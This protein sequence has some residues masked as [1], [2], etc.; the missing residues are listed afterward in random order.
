M[1]SV[2]HWIQSA[3]ETDSDVRDLGTVFT[4]LPE[5]P[6]APTGDGPLT[7]LSCCVKDV[8]DVGGWPTS[9]GSVGRTVT[10]ARDAAA[11]ARLRAAGASL[12]GKGNT[13][14][15][16]LG[17]D[18]LNPHHGPA[19][20]PHDPNRLAG[21]SSSGPA[22]AVASGLADIGLGTDTSGS[23]RVPAA[24]CGIVGVRPTL[25]VVPVCGVYP[26]ASA[27]D[28]VGPLA[29]DVITAA[30]A[31]A[32]LTG[33]RPV[34]AWSALDEPP[35]AVPKGLTFAVPQHIVDEWC[36][37]GVRRAL[38]AVLDAMRDVG[39]TVEEIRLPGLAEITTAHKIIQ[40]QQAYTVHAE[41]LRTYRDCYSEPVLSL[42]EQGQAIT[43][44][45]FDDAIG[46]REAIRSVLASAIRRFGILALPSAA[47]VAPPLATSTVVFPGGVT[48]VRGALLAMTIPFSQSPGPTVALPIGSDQGLPVGVQLH[49]GAGG[50]LMTLKAA[51][52]VERA[53]GAARLTTGTSASRAV[54]LAE[55][56]MVPERRMS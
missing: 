39:V 53:A 51:L 43:P 33:D 20:N 38:S 17:I 35:P 37:D 54:V 47:L 2:A 14:E 30:K 3:A 44:D 26:I 7:G 29:P 19:R 21:G 55:H 31:T 11:V 4:Y 1:T 41:A 10:P 13:N 32:V 45:Q 40:L 42:L 28:V 48:D 27:Y 5:L 52:L 36:T 49:G 23:L 25:G 50:E 6:L 15:F 8:I 9:F 34:A 24:L 12:V 22:V 16:A 56:R 46:A 18:G